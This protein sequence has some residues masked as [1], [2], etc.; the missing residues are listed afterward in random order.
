M[1]EIGKRFFKLINND[2]IFGNVEIV[3]G[4]NGEEILIKQPYTV[5]DGNAM[6]YMY[7]ELT[8]SPKAVQIHPINVLWSVPLDEFAG[9]NKIYIQATTGLIL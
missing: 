7:A 8:E 6:P 9:L 2:M 5:K 4:L 3:P 1:S